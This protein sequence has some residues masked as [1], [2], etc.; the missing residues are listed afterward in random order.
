[1]KEH[2]TTAAILVAAALLCLACGPKQP[3]SDRTCSGFDLDV[4]EVWSAS[5]KAEIQGYGGGLSAE[6]VQKVK[7]R[8]D[9]IAMDWAMLRESAC[10]D[11]QNGFISTEEYR[12]KVKCFDDFLQR[13]RTLLNALKEGDASTVES[14]GLGA[15]GEEVGSCR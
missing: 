6:Q 8:M 9:T 2:L 1:M 15:A 3:G 12:Q 5:V 4:E 10:L 7:T 14:L 13:Q 11:H